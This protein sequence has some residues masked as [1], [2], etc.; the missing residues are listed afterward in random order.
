M[1]PIALDMTGNARVQAAAAQALD[2]QIV[3]SNAGI[4]VRQPLVVGDLGKIHD[5]FEVNV[6]GPI[7]V[8]EAFA[9]VL[10]ANGGGAIV[11]A[12]PTV[13]WFSFPGMAGYSAT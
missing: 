7:Y 1:V 2:V 13:S 9:P 4:A 8:A 12:L 11:N 3:V 5:E 10:E 6:F